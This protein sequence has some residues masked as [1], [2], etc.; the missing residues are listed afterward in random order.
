LRYGQKDKLVQRGQRVIYQLPTADAL[1]L[2]NYQEVFEIKAAEDKRK[3]NLA[4]KR[5]MRVAIATKSKKFASSRD[6]HR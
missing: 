6:I 4:F 2:A 5:F 1:G 3:E